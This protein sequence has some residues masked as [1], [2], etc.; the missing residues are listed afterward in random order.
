MAGRIED[1]LRLPGALAAGVFTPDG[2]LLE[3]QSHAPELSAELGSLGARFAA[4]GTLV[5]ATLA[6][7]FERLSGQRW[8]PVE[9]WIGVGGDFVT[10][11]GDGCFAL[12]DLG[13]ARAAL[14]GGPVH[15][16]AQA[17]ALPGAADVGDSLPDGRLLEHRS[18][19]GLSDELAA[20]STRFSHDVTA[21]LRGLAGAFSA[22]ADLDFLP[23]HAWSYSGGDWTT[24][25]A[26]GRWVLFERDRAGLAEVLRLA[27]P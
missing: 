13:K 27:Q 16:F 3:F 23:L 2:R 7:G 8:N 15:T 24:V 11:V 10:H 18:R 21:V 22:A 14:P 12:L 9:R 19:I 1:A 17:L 6:A 26:R 25:V 4:A 20:V 5:L